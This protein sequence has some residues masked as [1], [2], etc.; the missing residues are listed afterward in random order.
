MK[1]LKN[2]A[3][4]LTLAMML[5]LFAGCGGAPAETT[6]APTEAATTAPETT[7]AEPTVPETVRQH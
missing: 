5:S 7:A 1:Y 6:A 4:V 3:L 2:L